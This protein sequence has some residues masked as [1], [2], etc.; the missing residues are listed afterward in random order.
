MDILLWNVRH[1]LFPV[2]VKKDALTLELT[3]VCVTKQ[4]EQLNQTNI[5]VEL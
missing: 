5:N 3:L 1:F 2:I 4:A